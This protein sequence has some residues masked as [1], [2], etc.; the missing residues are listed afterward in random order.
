[1]KSRLVVSGAFSLHLLHCVLEDLFVAHVSLDEMLEAGNHSLS[2]LVKLK[3]SRGQPGLK[4]VK[5]EIKETSAT[6]GRQRDVK[7]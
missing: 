2:L 7:Q 6:K 5:T 3:H 4:Y 1:M